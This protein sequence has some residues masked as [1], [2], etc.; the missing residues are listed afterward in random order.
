[1]PKSKSHKKNLKI[2][3]YIFWLAIR[4]HEAVYRVPCAVHL[5]AMV[6]ATQNVNTLLLSSEVAPLLH[7]LA[8]YLCRNCAVFG[9]PAFYVHTYAFGTHPFAIDGGELASWRT[10]KS[11]WM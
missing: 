1:M 5:T 9:V 2:Y 10:C 11:E 4:I 6:N 8:P 3:V 7:S